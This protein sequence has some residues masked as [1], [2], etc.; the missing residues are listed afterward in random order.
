MNLIYGRPTR[1]ETE[2][3]L[4]KDLENGNTLDGH[5]TKT[6]DRKEI[7][8]LTSGQG[9]GQWQGIPLMDVCVYDTPCRSGD[10]TSVQVKISETTTFVVG[11]NETELIGTPIDL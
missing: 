3:G 10:I 1:H 7:P 4:P 5:G 11:S 2:T 8:H 9:L 6:Q